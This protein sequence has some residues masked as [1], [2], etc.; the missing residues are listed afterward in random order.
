MDE[1]KVIE[2]AQILKDFCVN[3]MERACF[4]KHCPFCAGEV[5][6]FG[7]PASWHIPKLRRWTDADIALAK[8]LNAFGAQYIGGRGS[9]KFAY[10]IDGGCYAMPT[11]AFANL[12]AN[13]EIAIDEIIA[14]GEGR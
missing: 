11:G 6:M 9:V 1:K 5:C 13:E 7:E 8:A 14:E 4:T 3:E 12:N 10:C 2:A